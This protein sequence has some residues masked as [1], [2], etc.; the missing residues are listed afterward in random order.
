[1]MQKDIEGSK[2]LNH[3]KTPNTLFRDKRV[4]FETKMKQAATMLEKI[5]EHFQKPVLAVADSWFGNNGL[6]SLLEQVKGESLIYSPGC[7]VMQSC[8]TCYPFR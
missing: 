7:V 8:M 5:Y 6:W 4:T 2:E 1:M 3:K